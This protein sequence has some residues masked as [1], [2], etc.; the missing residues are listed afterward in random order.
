M[1]NKFIGDAV[2]GVF[3]APLENADHRNCALNA[4]AEIL[5]EIESL[6]AQLALQNL[7]EIHIGIG[8]HS[9]MA[10]AGTIGSSDRQ[11]Y[12][13]IGDV[14]NLASRLES[15]NKKL[16]TDVL[17]TSQIAE[18]A[19]EQTLMQA[20]DFEVNRLGRVQ[21][22]GKEKPVEIYTLKKTED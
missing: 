20:F 7:P 13:V 17:F 11:E 19:D 21:V 3:N 5:M 8:L 16:K 1:V 15:L 9:G 4:A 14:V 2:M 18:S 10:V 22:R 12:T 6:N